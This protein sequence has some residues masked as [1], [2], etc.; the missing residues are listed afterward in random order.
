MAEPKF[1]KDLERLEKIVEAL[2]SGELSLD[3]ALKRFEE[4]VKLTRRC[5]KALTE[6]EAKIEILLKNADGDLAA[7][8]FD[9]SED[10]GGAETA[11]ERPA[12]R[13]PGSAKRAEQPAPLAKRDEDADQEELPF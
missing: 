7:A 2:E 1:E 11:A 8:P 4:G 3:E 9:E 10:G 13:E 6:A 12:A 5:E